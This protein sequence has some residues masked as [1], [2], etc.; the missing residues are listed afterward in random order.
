[1]EISDYYKVKHNSKSWYIN[2]RLVAKQGLTE[3]EVDA[4]KALQV[5]RAVITDAMAAAILTGD[6]VR[7]AELKLAWT[8]NEFELQD[9]WKFPRN[10]NFHRFWDI[11]CCECPRMDNDERWPVGYYIYNAH[12]PVHGRVPCGS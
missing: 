12:C 11:P 7:L 8:E 4:I 1:M 10:E 6:P 9:A 2:P 3:V 5:K